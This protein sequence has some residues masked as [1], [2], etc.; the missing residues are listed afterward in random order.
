V[1][2]IHRLALNDGAAVL[3]AGEL[4]QHAAVVGVGRGNRAGPRK[5]DV[6]PS[7]A[8]QATSSI[9]IC[10]FWF[11]TRVNS[12]ESPTHPVPV[13][14]LLIVSVA[15]NE[16]KALTVAVVVNEFG[17]PKTIPAPD[18]VI[19]DPAGTVPVPTRLNTCDAVS[20][21]AL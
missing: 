5:L 7:A 4:V 15:V 10:G 21:H 2:G 11:S 1:F 20:S 8:L 3:V 9:V 12:S 16:P 14:G 17:E 18:H 13:A 19:V 6:P